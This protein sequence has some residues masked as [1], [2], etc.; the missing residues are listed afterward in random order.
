MGGFKERLRKLDSHSSVSKEF[1]VY[2]IHGAALSVVTCLGAWQETILLLISFGN[3]M[4]YGTC[5][6]NE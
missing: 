2:T 4:N 3:A 5:F 1:R 6:K